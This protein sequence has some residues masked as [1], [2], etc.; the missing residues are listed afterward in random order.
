MRKTWI[1]W[2]AAAAWGQTER[3]ALEGLDPVLLVEGQEMAGS[4]KITAR[5]NGFTYAFASPENKAKFE[6]DPARY[7]IQMEGSCA[8]M[9]HQA[10]GSPDA[11]MMHKGKIYI[12]GSPACYKLFSANPEKYLEPEAPRWSP[13]P[14]AAARGRALIDKAVEAMGGAARIDGLISYKEEASFAQSRP[15]GETR[16][17]TVAELAFPDRLRRERIF[18]DMAMVDVITP[19]EAYTEVRDRKFPMRPAG[20]DDT[21][22][23]ATRHPLV[24]LRA[25]RSA[26]FEAA[27]AGAGRAG[28][29]AVEQVAVRWNGVPVALGI[30]P[31]GKVL[32]LTWTGR[33]PGS[34]E[35]GEMQQVF[36]DFRAVDGVTLPFRT[37]GFFE[38]KPEAQLSSTVESITLKGGAVGAGGAWPG[39][40]GPRRDF[41]PEARGLARSWPE[42]G[43]R[44]LWSREL[45][46][47]YSGIVAVGETLYTMYRRGEQDVIVALEEA[48]GKTRWEHAYQAPFSPDYELANGSGPHSTPLVEGELLFA[49]GP[50]AKMH[51]LDKRTGK[52][53]WARDLIEEFGG[54][55]RVRGYSCSP[56]AYKDTVIVF[57]GGA[58]SSVLALRQKDGSV[59]WK[60]GDFANSHSS[61][62]LIRVDGQEQLVAFLFDDIVGLDPNDGRLLWRHPHK[63]DFGLNVSTPVWGEDNLLFCTSAYGGGARVLRLSQKDG[64][65]RVEEVWFHRQMR[66]HFGNVVRV[67]DYVYGSSGDFGP[68]PFT[69]VEVKTGRV[70]FRDRRFS[71]ANLLYADGRFLLLD[72]DGTLT[73]V[74]V[75][76]Q[77]VQ[78]HAQ[79][80]LM[81]H[82]AWTAPTLTGTRLYLR[83]RK[84]AMAVEL[85]AERNERSEEPAV[86]AR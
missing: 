44:R 38:G 49:V 70:V 62:L 2:L 17:R 13:T 77:G 20:R 78:V 35:V 21:W 18:P 53:V 74:S 51:A 56:L 85:G 9:G 50:T 65:T 83:D 16:V 12:F 33:R 41:K 54:T 73:L 37:E 84:T 80:A 6:A 29:A 63:T 69:A 68:T 47:G 60:S 64:Q 8:R 26:G 61:P 23:Q 40:G 31:G 14:A 24:I 52:K 5:H 34:G 79:A 82:N 7:Q 39:W 15:Q 59:V 72:E 10:G 4:D 66:V 3:P 67:D 32:S 55:V 46:E 58:G 36:S 27:S 76:P 25:R 28:E 57:A 86:L 48:T 30:D 22:R 42:G 81:A 71:K 45:G 19:S 75:T 1:L 43:P 11:Y